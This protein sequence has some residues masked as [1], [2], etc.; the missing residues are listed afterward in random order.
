MDLSRVNEAVET[1]LWRIGL[2]GPLPYYWIFIPLGAGIVLF[3]IA[4][5]MSPFRNGYYTDNWSVCRVETNA[6]FPERAYIQ[7]H[8]YGCYGYYND[9]I[10]YETRDFGETWQ[11]SDYKFT[12][13]AWSPS[14]TQLDG[15]A[16]V[17]EELFYNERKVWGFSR[18]WF[19]TFF[20][21]YGAYSSPYYAQYSQNAVSGDQVYVA[22]GQ[23]GVLIIPNPQLTLDTNGWRISNT[24]IAELVPKPLTITHPFIVLMI[25]ALALLIPPLPWFH[26]WLLGQVWSYAVPDDDRDVAFHLSFITA[27]EI[28]V[29]AVFAIILWLGY[30]EIDFYEIVGLMT[31]VTVGISVSQAVQLGKRFDLAAHQVKRL[32][33]ATG[34]VSLIVPIGVATTPFGFGWPVIITLVSGFI[35]YRRILTNYRNYMLIDMSRWQIDRVAVEMVALVAVAVV[36]FTIFFTALGPELGGWGLLGVPL[37]S[38]VTVGVYSTGRGQSF[39]PTSARKPHDGAIQLLF[40]SSE[41]R[42]SLFWNSVYWVGSAFVMSAVVFG[43]QAGVYAWFL[44]LGQY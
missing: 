16:M 42:G 36:T 9:P 34:I 27:V 37:L 22:L 26:A 29:V 15:L 19:R 10:A 3:V 28:S 33:I 40:N 2:R 6:T 17:G 8:R 5:T 31:L 7:L 23:H 4:V 20:T 13:E 11:R 32:A 41:W 35:I 38:I 1:F 30:I 21:Q 24:G 14:T 39:T 18:R 43:V 12:G 44:S 25:I